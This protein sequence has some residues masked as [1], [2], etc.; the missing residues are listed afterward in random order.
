MLAQRQSVVDVAP[1]NTPEALRRKRRSFPAARS[2][3]YSSLPS[4]TPEFASPIE[5]LAH[6]RPD[7]AGTRDER[8]ASFDGSMHEGEG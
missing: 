1:L 7:Q 3:E 8:S 4:Q 2:A 5:P 6:A